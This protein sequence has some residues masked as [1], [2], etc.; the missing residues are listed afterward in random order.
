MIMI[1]GLTGGIA[2]GKSTISNLLKTYG[3][4]V[5]DADQIARD[6]VEPGNDA[7]KQI[8]EHFGT[9]ILETDGTIAR[10]KL[11]TVIF[12][13]PKER[14]TLN[15]IVHPAIRQKMRDE[16]DR[17]FEE[18]EEVVVYDIPLL[19]ESDLRHMVD[20]TLLVYVDDNVQFERLLHRDQTTKEEAQSRI[21]SQ[22]P[23]T[24]KKSLADEVIDNNGTI[25]QT[26]A[27]LQAILKKWNIIIKA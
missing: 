10:K 20:K 9:E 1:I 8:V 27:Q 19:F 7:Y 21:N 22:M 6:V 24:E 13:D 14:K 4:A 26:E 11:G 16:K 2:S 23:L 18:G 12:N 15:G 17:Y 5:I 25:E 3:I